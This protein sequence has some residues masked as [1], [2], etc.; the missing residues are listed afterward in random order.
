MMTRKM[1]TVAMANQK[2]G[3]G[4]STTAVNLAAAFAQSGK[5][6]LLVDL[7]PQG[8]STLG[9]GFQ[10]T[11]NHQTVY[12]VLINAQLRLVSAIQKTSF[13]NLDIIPSDVML[14]GAELEI[15]TTFGRE[16][17]LHD[18]LNDL[19]SDYDMCII[20]CCPSLSLLTLNALSAANKILIPV[21]THYY[22]IEG[23]KQLLRTI[24]IAKSRFNDQL[25][26]LGILLTFVDRRTR[27]CQQV[28]QQ[29]R[30]FFGKLVFKTVIHRTIKLVEASSAGQSVLTYSPRCKAAIEYTAL[31]QEVEHRNKK[32]SW[33][34]K[35]TAVRL[36]NAKA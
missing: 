9:L 11:D 14:S 20:D 8:H 15:S 4:K 13:D 35:K 30:Q 23:L 5:K 19:T 33:P 22:A 18:K 24:D 7:D 2:G 26:I 34:I 16:Y 31:K 21:Q 1:I 10:P 29:M 36:E 32:V 28:V 27:L 6:V 17:I 25:S 3:C 12:N